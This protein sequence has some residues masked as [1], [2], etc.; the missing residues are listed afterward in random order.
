M[1]RVKGV[2]L[3]TVTVLGMSIA[4]AAAAAQPAPAPSP[5]PNALL[6]RLIRIPGQMQ[7]LQ[8]SSHNKQG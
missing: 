5:Q 7:V 1:L 4:L 6:E 2:A 3:S 8:T